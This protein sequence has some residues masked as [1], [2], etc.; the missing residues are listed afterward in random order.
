MIGLGWAWAP[1][2]YLFVW[3]GKKAKKW[4]SP[5]STIIHYII[6]Q[7]IPWI[8]CFLSSRKSHIMQIR[9]LLF[10]SHQSLVIYIKKLVELFLSAA[11]PTTG[12]ATENSHMSRFFLQS[13]HLSFDEGS[14]Y[15]VHRF[16]CLFFPHKNT[17]GWSSTGIEVY[18]T[19][20]SAHCRALLMCIKDSDRSFNWF[21]FFSSGKPQWEWVIGWTQI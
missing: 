19:P 11:P 10:F 12:I 8:T 13:E 21:R 6:Q 18:Y 20:S 4:K 17:M 2:K 15:C 5:V 14:I 9:A 3:V 1:P 7:P 16:L